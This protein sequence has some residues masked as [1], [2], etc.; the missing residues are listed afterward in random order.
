MEY[1]TAETAML[2][3][4]LFQFQSNSNALIDK[5]EI[6]EF[7]GQIISAINMK[8]NIISAVK[9]LCPDDII[10]LD[11]GSTV[12]GANCFR[13]N[14]LNILNTKFEK[15]AERPGDLPV[16]FQYSTFLPSLINYLDQPAAP[17]VPFVHKMEQFTNSCYGYFLKPEH[18]N[19]LPLD[20]F[21]YEA[22]IFGIFGGLFNIES[23]LTRFD[24]D[25]V[26]NYLIGS[27][28]EVAF[29]HFQTAVQGL[30]ADAITGKY[31]S[32]VADAIDLIGPEDIAK[33]VFYYMLKYREVPNVSSFDSAW[34]FA[35]HL[36]SKKYRDN[37]VV[38]RITMAAVLSGIKS[39]SKN[40][41]SEYQL[42][43]I[44]NKKPLPL[45]TP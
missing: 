18:E 32:I 39:S 27:E 20:E 14:F 42:S 5:Y 37:V 4:D 36:L 23:T 2:M 10:V 34:K 38:D 35:K 12:Y 31:A 11:N 15:K 40:K 7:G 13:E 28:I 17:K 6:A 24:T 43:F 21:L 3:N 9:N 16:M 33:K 29:Q 26:D 8:K 1:N 30:L 22:D 41:P 44:C 25:P 19:E 45:P